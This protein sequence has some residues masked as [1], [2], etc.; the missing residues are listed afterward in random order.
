MPCTIRVFNSNPSMLWPRKIR[1]GYVSFPLM[2]KLAPEIE[3]RVPGRSRD[4]GAG[5][6]R[7]GLTTAALRN[8]LRFIALSCHAA[9]AV[10]LNG[11]T[12]DGWNTLLTE[13][14]Y[15]RNVAA[16]VGQ[17]TGPSSSPDL[18]RLI[19]ITEVGETASH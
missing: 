14:P 8:V 7:A 16:H 4:D 5:W 3:T 17:H 19:F 1:P 10:G 13:V 6:E 11:V 18:R 9:V 2:R 12:C 15:P